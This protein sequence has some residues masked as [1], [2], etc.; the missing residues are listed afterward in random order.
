[1]R[2][3]ITGSCALHYFD[4]VW[5]Y[6]DVDVISPNGLSS[7]DKETLESVLGRKCDPTVLPYEIF[8]LIPHKEGRV[9]PDAIYTILCSHIGWDSGQNNHSKL[10]GSVQWDK[11][12]QRI[13]HLR[14]IGCEL[15]PELYEKLLTHW[16]KEFGNKEFLS[17][18]KDK[19][20]FFNDYVPYKYDHD[21]LHDVVAYP[22]E[23]MYNLCLERGEDVLTSKEMFDKMSFEQQI[24]MF[25]E[26]ICVIALERWVIPC[27]ESFHL[28]WAKS[29]K[30]TITQLTKNWATEFLVINLEKFLKPDWK[31]YDNY[32]SFVEENNK[33][34][35][36]K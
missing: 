19:S 32:L 23:P 28:S 13:L 34:G 25:R 10:G 8:C 27:N 36:Y 21:L 2:Y 7:L 22:N 14:G 15:I 11:Y 5:E 16:K 12:K 1:M 26:E 4:L 35:E 17:L 3:L 20:D 6:N 9:T 18:K 24:Q 30:K 33:T 31:M 29:L